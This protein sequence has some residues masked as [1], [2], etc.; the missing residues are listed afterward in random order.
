MYYPPPYVSAPVSALMQNSRH[1]N[2]LFQDVKLELNSPKLVID[3]TVEVSWFI[4]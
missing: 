2:T 3:A 1:K 4:N